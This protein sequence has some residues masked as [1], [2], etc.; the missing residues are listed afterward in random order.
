MITRNYTDTDGKSRFA[1]LPLPFVWEEGRERT[2]L[3]RATGIRF[4]RWPVGRF[5]D[6]HNPRRRQ[7]VIILAGH[8]EVGLEDGTVHTLKP[9]DVA[10]EEDLTGRGHTTR[11]VGDHPLVFVTVPLEEAG[12]GNA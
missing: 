7:Y 12:Q 9:G 5:L 1:D 11:V 3:Q 2:P 10:L 4:N 8:V 6:W